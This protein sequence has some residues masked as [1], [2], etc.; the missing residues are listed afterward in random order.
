MPCY[1]TFLWPGTSWA[2]FSGPCWGR[3][4]HETRKGFST[5][6][7]TKWLCHVDERGELWSKQTSG[8]TSWYLVK[9]TRMTPWAWFWCHTRVT[10]LMSAGLFLIDP[11][12][13]DIR[14]RLPV[15]WKGPSR[16]PRMWAPNVSR[17]GA[18]L[19]GG[20]F[21]LTSFRLRFFK[22]DFDFECLYFKVLYWHLKGGLILREWILKIKPLK[23]ISIWTPQKRRQPKTISPLWKTWS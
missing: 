4:A 2:L 7:R 13:T 15:I 12:V 17:F 8:D 10:P 1:L 23:G 6:Q 16:A 18:N 21:F 19:D 3:S 14:M 20:L 22:R 11:S 9:G 5:A